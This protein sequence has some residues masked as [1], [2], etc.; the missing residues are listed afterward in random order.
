MTFITFITWLVAFGLTYLLEAAVY[1]LPLVQGI[2]AKPKTR[3][4]MD[5]LMINACTHPFIF[6]VLPLL[7]E[8]TATTYVVV[9]EVFAI[10]AEA[11]ML[12]RFGYLNPW[13]MSAVAN[14]VSW[15]FGS[16]LLYGVG[17]LSY[18][19]SKFLA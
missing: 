15:C 13:R 4:L 2:E 16:W 17:A 6:L 3:R 11:L 7:I 9:A 5:C 1:H 14:V 19:L 12:K 18:V 10:T 8:D